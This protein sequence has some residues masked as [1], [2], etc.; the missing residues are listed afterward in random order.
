[1]YGEVVGVAIRFKDGQTTTEHE[2][3]KWLR[4][5]VASHK[6]PSY[7]SS[8]VNEIRIACILLTYTLHS[9]SSI[10][11]TRYLEQLPARSRDLLSRRICLEIRLR[12]S[13]LKDCDPS[14]GLLSHI[15]SSLANHMK[16]RIHLIRSAR[17]AANSFHSSRFRLRVCFFFGVCMSDD[18]LTRMTGTGDRTRLTSSWDPRV[19]SMSVACW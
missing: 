9:S 15:S 17:P 8:I 1:M 3:K 6:I 5:H 18:L 19:G 16:F 12:K 11:Q 14:L 13:T 2:L 10:F 4:E 7:V